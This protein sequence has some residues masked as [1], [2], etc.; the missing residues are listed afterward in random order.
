MSEDMQ[1]KV[2]RVMS[3][4]SAQLIFR[5]KLHSRKDMVRLIQ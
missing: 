4:T 3:I 1:E 2:S 5:S